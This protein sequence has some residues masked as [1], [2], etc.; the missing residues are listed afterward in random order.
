MQMICVK[1]SGIMGMICV[2]VERDYRNDL[3]LR[4]RGIIGMFC[5]KVERDHG[6]DLC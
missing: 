4:W 2:K 5:V 1:W 6:N 3:C